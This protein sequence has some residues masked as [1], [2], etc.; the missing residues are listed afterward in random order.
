MKMQE[1][2][3]AVQQSEPAPASGGRDALTAVN[4]PGSI[5]DISRMKHWAVVENLFG[6]QHWLARWVVDLCD[7]DSQFLIHLAEQPRGYA[8][9]LCLIRMALLEQG[10]DYGREQDDA[11]MLRAGNKREL[12][13]EL[14]PSCPAAIINLL[15]KLPKKPMPIEAYRK[16]I[17]AMEDEKMR[18]QLFHAERIK[19]AGIFMLDEIAALPERFRSVAMRCIKNADD[20]DDFHW[21]LHWVMVAIEKLG[22][23]ITEQELDKAFSRKGGANAWLEKKISKLPFPEPPWDGDDEIRPIRSLNELK[24]AAE[25]LENCM[26]SSHHRRLYASRVVTGHS[27]FYVCD[28]IPAM[29]EV[30]HDGFWGWSVFEIEGATDAQKSEILKFFRACVP[31]AWRKA[32][33]RLDDDFDDDIPF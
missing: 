8:H 20:V 26:T 15:P 11:R 19:E 18:K 29:V 17:C 13:R 30:R 32:T 28:H 27:Y 31:P 23:K 16:L 4:Q 3:A 6:E 2:D 33:G 14:F 22:L 7:A 1:Q 21:N 9:F 5:L 12:L 25:R 10:A 24:M